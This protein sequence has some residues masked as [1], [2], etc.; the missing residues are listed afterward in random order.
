MPLRESATK[1]IRSAESC[2]YTVAFMT[3]TA[4]RLLVMTALSTI[5]FQT[6]MKIL[7]PAK[8]KFDNIPSGNDPIYT[9]EDT[10]ASVTLN[11]H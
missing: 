4:Q 9:A 5:E 3:R 6:R 7:L 11:C 2:S 10:T 1:A 8:L